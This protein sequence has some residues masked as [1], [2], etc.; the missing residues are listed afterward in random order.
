MGKVQKNKQKKKPRN[1]AARSRSIIWH[2]VMC[3]LNRMSEREREKWTDF[4]MYGERERERERE[5]KG[6]IFTKTQTDRQMKT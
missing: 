6:T 2:S 4:Q 3:V 1:T 5:G